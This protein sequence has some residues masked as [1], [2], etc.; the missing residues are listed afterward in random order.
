M[1]FQAKNTLKITTTTLSNTFRDLKTLSLS[2][3]H[4]VVDYKIINF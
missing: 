2:V 1:Y 4:L 3:F